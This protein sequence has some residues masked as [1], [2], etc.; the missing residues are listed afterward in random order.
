M[1]DS[2]EIMEHTSGT[3]VVVFTRNHAVVSDYVVRNLT[4]MVFCYQTYYMV[5]SVDG[6]TEM[7]SYKLTSPFYQRYGGLILVSIVRVVFTRTDKRTPTTNVAVL[8]LDGM[9]SIAKNGNSVIV[10]KTVSVCVRLYRRVILD[11]EELNSVNMVV[12]LCHV[13]VGFH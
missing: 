5:D 13:V 10:V 12:V 4:V 6:S 7:A 1:A 2:H 3:V 8:V 11:R 9:G